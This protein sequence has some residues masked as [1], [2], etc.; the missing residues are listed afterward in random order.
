M[1][2]VLS[3]SSIGRKELHQSADLGI[4]VV[5]EGGERLLEAGRQS[6]LVLAQLGPWLDPGVPRGQLGARGDD[7]E[8]ELALEVS[9]AD[10]VPPL[11]VAAPVLL[12]VLGRGLVG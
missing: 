1:K 9:L 11:V 3:S 10:D 8:V 4:G 5:E 12:E 6:L 2:M 7:P